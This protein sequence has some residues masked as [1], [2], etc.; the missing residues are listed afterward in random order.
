M[1]KA[2]EARSQRRERLSFKCVAEYRLV[3]PHLCFSEENGMAQQQRR[4]IIFS[5]FFFI[6][7]IK[8][9]KMT[10][11]WDSSAVID[12]AHNNESSSIDTLLLFHPIHPS[13]SLGHRR[14]PPDP[15]VRAD[16]YTVQHRPIYTSTPDGESHVSAVNHCE[17]THSQRLLGK[18]IMTGENWLRVTATTPISAQSFW[19]HFFFFQGTVGGDVLGCPVFFWSRYHRNSFQL[20][21]TTA[22]T[23]LSQGVQCV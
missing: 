8:A 15:Q 16:V 10:E 3:T 13:E 7:L 9:K 22:T 12:C 19:F 4:Q 5:F 1:P 23:V 17:H 2:I 18:N 21:V 14:K 20:S 11:P 6:F